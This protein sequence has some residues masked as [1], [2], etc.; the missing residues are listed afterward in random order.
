MF[1]IKGHYNTAKIFAAKV[2]ETAYQQIQDLCNNPNYKGSNIAIMPD[3]HAGKGCT[4][5]TTMTITDSVEPNLTGVDIGCLDQDTE[6][7]TP[8]GWIK[9]SNYQNESILTYDKNTDTASFTTPITYIKLPCESF[10]EL[11]TKYGLDQRISDEHNILFWRGVKGRGYKVVEQKAIDFVNHHN[12]LAKGIQGGI[13]TTFNLCSKGLNFTEAKIRLIVMISA[14][15]C[16]RE[17]VVADYNKVELHFTKER[18]IAR[19]KQLLQENNIPFNET[20]LKDKSTLIIFQISKDIKKDLS[21][22]WT[23]SQTELKILAEESLI[24]DG[25]IGEH[26]YYSSTSKENADIIQFAFATNKIRCGLHTILPKNSN[27]K[28]TYNVYKTQN[29][30]VHFP[31]RK[32]EKVPSIDGF[33]YCFTTETGFFIVR[34]NNK[35]SITGNCGIMAIKFRA[36]CALQLEKIDNIIHTIPSGRNIHDTP[37]CNTLPITL[38]K[39]YDALKNV[40]RITNSLGTLGGGNHFIEFADTAETNTYYCFIHSGS[41][42]LGVQ[43][44]SYYQSLLNKPPQ[45]EDYKPLI[46]LVKSSYNPKAIAPILE[47]MKGFAAKEEHPLTL[48]GENFRK[49][50]CDMKMVQNWAR[51]NRELIWEQIK[52]NY[53]G[54]IEVKQIFQTVHN[55][56]DTDHRPAILRKGAIAAYEGQ[57]CAIPLNMRDGTLICRGLGNPLWNYSA[58]HGAGRI[59]SRTQAREQLTMEQF[60][61]SMCGIYS[62]TVNK[63]TLDEAPQAYK[64]ARDIIGAIGDTVDIIEHVQPIYNFKASE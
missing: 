15:G 35:I 44:C 45:T 60:Q 30:I 27:W 21:I 14:D 55:Y 33:K 34:R 18:K 63:S 3:V 28:I 9:I 40:D 25:H 8:T 61:Q 50:I 29:E 52:K 36:R 17:N 23:A 32:I 31:P 58:P 47:I 51:N 41:R 49:Y 53:G 16:I 48:M 10:F 64:P 13:K 56:I 7:L 46:D 11:K 59:M 37:I 4:I 38:L 12:S 20:M 42:N 19:A 2:E 6:I 24:W 22:F 1:T 57:L 54:Y 5:G 43:V 62:S 26:E 39:C